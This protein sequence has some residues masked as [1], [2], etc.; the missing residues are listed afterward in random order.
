MLTGVATA[1]GWS[2]GYAG[3]YLLPAPTL[4]MLTRNQAPLS[5]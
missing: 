5:P 1:F 2:A 4:D 3:R